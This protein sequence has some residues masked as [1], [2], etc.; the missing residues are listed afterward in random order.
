MK[1]VHYFVAD[2]GTEFD[3]EEECV[4]HE[5]ENEL[6]KVEDLFCFYDDKKVPIALDGLTAE[7]VWYIRVDDEK[8]K[9]SKKKKEKIFMHNNVLFDAAAFHG[10]VLKDNA[11]AVAINNAVIGA[12]SST[13]TVVF[14]CYEVVSGYCPVNAAVKKDMTALIGIFKLV[15]VG[16]AV[17][18]GEMKYQE[19]LDW[20]LEN[21]V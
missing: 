15:P 17:A 18:A 11:L 6:L 14:A 19:L 10:I 12:C 1:E 7:D 21:E 9:E 3:N 2:D 13:G 8:I 20:I 16:L 4:L 5:L